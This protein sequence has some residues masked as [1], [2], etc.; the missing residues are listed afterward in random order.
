MNKRHQTLLLALG[1]LSSSISLY[2]I[3]TS[4][5]NAY[6]GGN[7]LGAEGVRQVSG[8]TANQ[9]TSNPGI[10]G[11]VSY[12][13]YDVDE[14]KGR[15]FDGEYDVLS[16]SIGYVHEFGGWKIGGAVS[17]VDT[18]FESVGT[19]TNPNVSLDTDGDGWIVSLG[20]SKEWDKWSLILQG[21][22]GELSLDSER[23]N[24]SF[25]TKT[26]DYD[27]SLYY[28]SAAVYYA[29]LENEDWTITPFAELGYMTT[30]TD[31]FTESN[32]TPDFVS[33]DE[34]EDDV[35]YG[36]IGAEIEYLGF[37]QFTPFL[38]LAVWQD[39]G[40]DEVDVD[41][42]DSIS[43]PFEFEIPDAAETVFSIAT[44]VEIEVTENFDMGASVG[45][46]SGDD[47]DGYNLALSG[48][49]TF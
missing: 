15:R 24:G 23:E 4:D 41:G 21:G 19:D 45:Y 39:L 27:T 12:G 32:S 31:G 14:D 49:F 34:I 17:F 30:E 22:I 35:P 29:L 10:A 38:T 33:L 40:D 44:G 5:L 25:A 43:A 11:G 47:I 46:F 1:G 3:N 26:S 7:Y 42:S 18:D 8:F 2:A 9:L 37:S 16:A 6:T 20:A 28:L 36:K 13:D 48:V